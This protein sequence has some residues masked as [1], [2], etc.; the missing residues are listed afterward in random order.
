M[1]LPFQSGQ[2]G[3]CFGRLHLVLDRDVRAPAHSI[4]RTQHSM[5]MIGDFRPDGIQ[6]I[7]NGPEGYP[8][9][10]VHQAGDRSP[11]RRLPGDKGK[12]PLRLVERGRRQGVEHRQVRGNLV[13]IRRVMGPAKSFQPGEI[14]LREF[15]R[16]DQAA[17]IST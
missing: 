2:Q 11:R 16:D 12:L 1:E 15:G 9:A 4:L 5:E 14:V 13:A 10:Q 3:S 8:A 7:G 17:Q 6:V